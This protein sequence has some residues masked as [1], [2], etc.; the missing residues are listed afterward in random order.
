MCSLYEGSSFLRQ[1]SRATIVLLLGEAEV[2]FRPSST[3]LL[4]DSILFLVKKNKKIE[5]TCR[6]TPHMRSKEF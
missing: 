4:F 6:R 5:L 2:G 1:E 3:Q